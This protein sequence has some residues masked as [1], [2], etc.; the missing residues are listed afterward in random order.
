MTSVP[1][2]ATRV[3]VVDDEPGL[4]EVLSITFRREGFEVSTASGRAAA[5]EML[6]DSPQPFPLV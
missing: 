1:P 2:S 5:V 3:L 6:R 4:R